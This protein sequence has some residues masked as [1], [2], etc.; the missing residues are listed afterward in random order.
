MK[1]ANSNAAKEKT[2]AA[3]GVLVALE[4][5]NYKHIFLI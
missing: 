2:K 5:S 1:L 4:K 3:E